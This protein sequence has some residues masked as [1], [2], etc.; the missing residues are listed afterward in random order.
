[1]ADDALP[2]DQQQ[3]Q[4]VD[5]HGV[6]SQPHAC[7]GKSPVRSSSGKLSFSFSIN[8]ISSSSL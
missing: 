5:E 8:Y 3:G 1:M 2:E 4:E 6:F 7:H